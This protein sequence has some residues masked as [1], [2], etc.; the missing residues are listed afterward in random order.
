MAVIRLS[1]V[2]WCQFQF[3]SILPKY[4]LRQVV[5]KYETDYNSVIIFYQVTFASSYWKLGLYSNGST[6]VCNKTPTE[7]SFLAS[8]KWFNRLNLSLTG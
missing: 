7:P 3:F 5:K 2:W 6:V 8:R 4:G 1:N